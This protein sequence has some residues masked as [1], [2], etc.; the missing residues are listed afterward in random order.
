ML[1]DKP[2][3]LCQAVR[4]AFLLLSASCFLVAE[5]HRDGGSTG[6]MTAG[7]G[8]AGLQG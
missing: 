3:W 5:G 8:E 6:F 7:A 1:A 4:E 2:Q